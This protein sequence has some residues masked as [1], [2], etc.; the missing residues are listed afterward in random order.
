MAS[1]LDGTEG[2]EEK[3]A[4]F[5]AALSIHLAQDLD[6]SKE[7]MQWGLQEASQG[8]P[9]RLQRERAVATLCA[10]FLH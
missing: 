6:E 7:E 2:L 8:Y 9:L 10:E 5:I 4:P 1:N 3:P